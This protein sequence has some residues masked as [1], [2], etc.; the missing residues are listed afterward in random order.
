MA[1]LNSEYLAFDS[2]IKLTDNRKE[3]LK[4]SRKE[5][6][7][8]I[9]KYFRE[10]KPD[11][12][13]PKFWGQGSFEMNTTVNPI[14]VKDEN[15]E[16]LLKYDL[17]Y[18]VYFV[19]KDGEDN[20]KSIEIWHNWVF[21]A[22]ENHTNTP[23]Q[24]KTTC[25]RVI[26]AD[27]HHIDLPI[28]YKNGNIPELAHKSKGWIDSDPKEFYEWFNDK[29]NTQL[30]RIVRYLK[31][32]KNYRE[33]NNESLVLPS[34]FILT[35]LATNNYIAYDNDDT[36]FRETIKK[37]KKELDRKFEC[38]RPTTPKDE[39]LFASYKETKKTNFL[40]ALQSLISNCEKAK[41]ENNF[42]K[43]SEHLQYSFGDRFPLG[44]DKNEEEK[45]DKIGALLTNSYASKP[46]FNGNY[47]Y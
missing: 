17:D 46:Y 36:A 1:T 45:K 19:E 38:Y 8:K 24:K 23:P 31:A 27:G 42:K 10:E 12:L 37:I 35:I 4:K 3:K 29:A 11:E 18:G 30:K 40:E 41:E 7:N 33:T 5:I 21:N 26:F 39:D 14:P 13:Q 32:W 15:D 34:G 22:V 16:N 2:K 28:Y 20:R 44:Q 43:A 6:K 47:K 9:K 25:V